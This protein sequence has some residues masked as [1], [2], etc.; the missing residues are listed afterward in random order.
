MKIKESTEVIKM[1]AG[2]D[3]GALKFKMGAV[4]TP[5]AEIY[6]GVYEVTPT[7]TALELPT[8][9]KLLTDNVV[10]NEIP[11]TEIQNESGTTVII[12]E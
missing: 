8:R 10:I 7:A 11:Y 12:G 4:V 3:T 2:K 5:S 6:R 9:N 1:T